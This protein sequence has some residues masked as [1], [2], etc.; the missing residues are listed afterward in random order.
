[1][2]TMEHQIVEGVMVMNHTEQNPSDGEWEAMMNEVKAFSGGLSDMPSL[3]RTL[4]GG[5]SLKQRARIAEVFNKNAKVAI[6]TSSKVARS[7]GVAVSWFMPHVRT[8]ELSAVDEA[9]AHLKLTPKQEQ[10]VRNVLQKFSPS[11]SIGSQTA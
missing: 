9:L 5:P 2:K 3:V 8:F 7:V 6:I 4:G 10:A 1:M 11:T